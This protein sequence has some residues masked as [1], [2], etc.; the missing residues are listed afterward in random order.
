MFLRSVVSE[1]NVIVSWWECSVR[2]QGAQG[3]IAQRKLAQRRG[4]ERAAKLKPN[5]FVAVQDRE[6]G[7]FSVPFLIGI[8]V[9]VGDGSCIVK[10]DFTKQERIDKTVFDPGVLCDA[11]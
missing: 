3:I 8:T 2:L 9:D 11:C 6:D 1:L 10:K 4:R 7:D 5:T